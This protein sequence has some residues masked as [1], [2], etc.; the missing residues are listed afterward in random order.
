MPP[1]TTISANDLA[2]TIAQLQKQ[3]DQHAAAIAEI[4]AAFATFGVKSGGK[5]GAGRP[6]SDGAKPK[7]KRKRGRFAKTADQFTLDLLKKNKRLTTRQINVKWKQAGR[8]GSADNVLMTLTKEKQIKR[9]NIKGARGSNYSLATGASKKKAAKKKSGGNK[10]RNKKAT[11]KKTVK[12]T[13]AKPE[14]QPATA[15]SQGSG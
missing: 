4:D 3:R 8:G 5:R 12:K 10:T 7:G 14:T 2:R 15:E 1:K 9:E 6:K 13:V 11:T